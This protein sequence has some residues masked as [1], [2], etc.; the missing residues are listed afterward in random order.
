MPPAIAQ[1]VAL[2]GSVVDTQGAPLAGVSVRVRPSVAKAVQ[3]DATGHF[4]LA[5]V[6]SGTYEVTASKPGFISSTV[7]A[8]QVPQAAPVAFTLRAESLST[9]QQIATVTASATSTYNTSASAIATVSRQQFTDQGQVQI[10][11]VLD[12]TPGVVSARPG[13]ANAA[14]PGSITSPNLRGALDYEKAT[15]LDGHPLINGARGDY[16][17]M[18]VNS[19]LFDDVEIVKGPTAYAP[20]INYGIGG[21]LNFRTGDPTPQQS[22]SMLLGFDNYSG[23]IGSVRLSDTIGKLGYL[24]DYASYGTDGPLQQYPS[25]ISLPKGALVNG[26]TVAGPTTSAKPIN[27]VAGP[28]P[29]AGALGSP[30]AGYTSLVACCQYVNSNFLNRGELAKLQY[31]FSDSTVFSAAYIGIQSNYDAPAGS[32]TEVASV[33][34]PAAVYD[35]TGTPFARGQFFS[36]NT[37]PTLPDQRTYDNE[38]MFEANLRTT[39]NNDTILAR[40]YSAVLQRA[41]YSD[42]TS[43]TS[44]YT[45][46]L[47]L[48]GTA[49]LGNSSNAPTVFNGAPATITVPASAAYVN[50]TSDHDYLH[51]FSFQ[52]D[53]PVGSNVYTFAYDRNTSLTN[54]YKI[55]GGTGTTTISIPGGTRQDFN[56]YLLRGVF[57]I[58][59]KLQLTLANYYN[60]Y[61]SL[62]TP[63]SSNGVFTFT[64]STATHDDPRLGLSYLPNANVAVRF[65][66]GSAI[67]P[68]YPQLIDNLNT[69]PATTQP[70]NGTI[71]ISQNSGSLLPETSF[72][73]DLGTDVR[74]Q[75]GNILSVDAY[76]T[77]IR[78]Q[79]VGIVYPSGT[80]FNG[81]PV[82]ITTNANLA[83][84]R[85]E[86]LEASLRRDPVRGYGYTVSGSLQRAYA[87]NV[88]PGFYDS[89]AGPLTTNLGVVPGLNYI[90]FNAPAF[91]GISN[92]SEAYAM[93][94]AE[95]HRRGSF[96]QFTQL[97][98]TYY[99]PNNTYNM[100]VFLV[101]SASYRQPIMR[102]TA[103]QL[104]VDNLFGADAGKH[105]QYGASVP[106]P[107][108]NGQ[109]G[110]RN[111]VPYG[112]A[113]VRFIITH[114]F[115]Q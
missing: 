47:N 43:P 86:G 59:D 73:Y 84:S 89:A 78:N 109:V 96:G 28:Y 92:K 21:T 108:A 15:L 69:N 93:G 34:S 2:S 20:E 79:F 112:P 4:T 49:V 23:T 32:L 45:S 10:G 75:G 101:G 11:H 90:G 42:A 56:T 36:L 80:S 31:H 63:S 70:V 62:Y 103:V 18:L 68:P 17:T 40:Y 60:V 85:Y 77:N 19:L 95:V 102:D 54:S 61:Q 12:Q 35:S 82:Y 74:L 1:S 53:H 106:A 111:I 55:N 97:G 39:L 104:S 115:G 72:G 110:L 76:Q 44:P 25:Y 91:N 7:A 22:G 24:L 29:V 98:L 8:V 3:T 5:G 16:P 99:G 105:V 83:S 6:P 33:F 13:S 46:T 38:P 26:Q 52:Y 58:S 66:A 64:H 9:L 57:G 30:N 67:A 113:T 51:G 81:T 65:S 48:Y 87:Y 100:P 37:T 71:T 50:N 107:L 27:G 14:A 41:T 114:S 94:Y 88:P